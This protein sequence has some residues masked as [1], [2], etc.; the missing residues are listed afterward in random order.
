M[1]VGVGVGLVEVDEVL[2]EG[3]GVVELVGTG[4]V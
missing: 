3:V 4:R 1:L 2:F